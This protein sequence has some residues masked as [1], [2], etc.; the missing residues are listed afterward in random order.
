[1]NRTYAEHLRSTHEPSRDPHATHERFHDEHA[2]W[3]HDC[4]TP[5]KPL[6]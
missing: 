5:L 1:M 6:T 4:R 2:G 3:C